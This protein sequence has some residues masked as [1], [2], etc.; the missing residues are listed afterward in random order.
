MGGLLAHFL[1]QPEHQ[2]LG[3]DE[4]RRLLHVAPDRGLVDDQVVQ[5]GPHE[6]KGAAGIQ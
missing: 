5:D 6:R 3:G 2:G 4:A 1:G